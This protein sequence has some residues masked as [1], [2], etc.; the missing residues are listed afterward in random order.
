M[1]DRL[2]A[3]RPPVQSP[4]IDPGLTSDRQPD[5]AGDQGPQDAV[6]RPLPVELVEDQA[7]DVLGLLVGV[8]RDQTGRQLDIPGRDADDQ[9]PA[10]G[11]VQLPLMHPLLEDVELGLVHHPGQ[12]EQE[13]IRVIRR[14][15]HPVG[16]GEQDA[17]AGAELEQVVPV[18]AGPGQPARLQPEDQPDPIQGHLGEQPLE[19]RPSFDR[20]AALA[21]VVVDHLDLRTGPAEGEGAIGQGVLAG[22]RFLMVEDLLGGR[23][24]DVDDRGPVE[25]PRPELRGD[26]RIRRWDRHGAPPAAGPPRRSRPGRADRRGVAGASACGPAGVGSRRRSAG[27]A[28]GPEAGGHSVKSFS[29]HGLSPWPRR[30]SHHAASASRASVAM[31]T[32]RSCDAQ[33][34]ASQVFRLGDLN[35]PVP[36]AESQQSGRVAFFPRRACDAVFIFGPGYAVRR[37]LPADPVGLPQTGPVAPVFVEQGRGADRPLFASAMGFGDVGR[38]SRL[39][40][41]ELLLSGGKAPIAGRRRP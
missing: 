10:A 2:P 16:V 34:V 39:A 40:V 26:G 23:L 12:A 24:P 11:L 4:A 28:G 9:L 27:P 30:R 35:G 7:D 38:V 6:D 25:M 22:G 19:A 20:L 32:G 33:V 31:V 41:K 15:I 29:E 3:R 14:V 5:P 36:A 21:Q 17:E 13:A 8:E 37:D 18:L 1:T